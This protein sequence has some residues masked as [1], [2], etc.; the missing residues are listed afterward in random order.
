MSGET[1]LTRAANALIEAL[2]N[3]YDGDE[4]DTVLDYIDCGRVDAKDLV[5]AALLAIR[6][7]SECMI[8]AAYRA[9]HEPYEPALPQD[10]FTAMID[11]ILNESPSQSVTHQTGDKT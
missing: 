3:C 6:E 7:S 1:M 9:P 5:R 8:D 10:V 4:S 2:P 11:A